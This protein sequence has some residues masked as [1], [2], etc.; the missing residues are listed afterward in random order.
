MSDNITNTE[1]Q[2]RWR[3]A[4]MWAAVVAQ[5]V[6]IAGL[7]GLW[8]KIGITSDTFQGI[9]TAV[10]TILTLFGVLNNPTSKTTF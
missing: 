8:D 9:A 10:L 4:V 2:P 6:A 5:V 3:S 1:N 7:A